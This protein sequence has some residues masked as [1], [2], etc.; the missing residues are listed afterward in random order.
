MIGNTLRAD[1]TPRLALWR[2]RH[3]LISCRACDPACDRRDPAACE[4]DPGFGV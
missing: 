3:R 1:N 4:S 2:L